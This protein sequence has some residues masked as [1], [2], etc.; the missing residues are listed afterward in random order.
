MGCAHVVAVCAVAGGALPGVHRPAEELRTL[1]HPPE[2]PLGE[3]HSTAELARHWAPA[4][5]HDTDSSHYVGDYITHFNYD[6][7]YN[8][9]N[10]WENLGGSDGQR[11]RGRECRGDL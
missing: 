10:N 7:D 2:A 6:G 11:R 5:F 1:D 9:K 3:R 8:G 4:F